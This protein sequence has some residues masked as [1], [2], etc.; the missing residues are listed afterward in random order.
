LALPCSGSANIIHSIRDIHDIDNHFD[1]EFKI[2]ILLSLIGVLSAFSASALALIN[3]W[4]IRDWYDLNRYVWMPEFCTFCFAFWFSGALLA[5]IFYSEFP[6]DWL[7]VFSPFG[8]API[9]RYIH[10]H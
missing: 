6:F 5:L 7:F 1:M 8:A 4:G 2:I 10:E 3:K 9:A